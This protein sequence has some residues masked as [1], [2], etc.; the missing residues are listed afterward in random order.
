MVHC[1]CILVDSENMGQREEIL[2]ILKLKN[3]Y[4]TGKPKGH[5][6]YFICDNILI[7]YI[8]HYIILLY[9]KHLKV[10]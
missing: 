9:E 6:Y 10:K 3:M 8:K 5:F 7:K 4:I 1:I 2:T